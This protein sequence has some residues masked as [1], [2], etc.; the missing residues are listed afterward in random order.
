MGEFVTDATTTDV[1]RE[2]L[3]ERRYRLQCFG[4]LD[5]TCS[6]GLVYRFRSMDQIKKAIVS[7]VQ[8]FTYCGAAASTCESDEWTFVLQAHGPMDNVIPVPQEM[9]A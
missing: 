6:D 3:E 8:L 7:R 4:F 2:E 9:A 5:Y 1:H